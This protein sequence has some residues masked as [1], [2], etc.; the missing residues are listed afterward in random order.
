[1]KTIVELMSGLLLLCLGA[2]LVVLY[3]EKTCHGNWFNC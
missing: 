2:T 1:M 3:L